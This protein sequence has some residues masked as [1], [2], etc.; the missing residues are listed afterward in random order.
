MIQAAAILQA[1]SG[2]DEAMLSKDKLF[3]VMA[4]VLIIWFGIILFLYRGDRK[5]DRLERRLDEQESR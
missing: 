4:V 1:A 3:V 2:L 5:L